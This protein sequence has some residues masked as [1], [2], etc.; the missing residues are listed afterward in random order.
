[1]F[2]TEKTA[3]D[4]RVTIDSSILDE[5]EDDTYTNEDRKEEKQ[6]GRLEK[7]DETQFDNAEDSIEKNKMRNVFKVSVLL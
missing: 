3:E 2:Y 5:D 7:L 4:V 6:R 1:M